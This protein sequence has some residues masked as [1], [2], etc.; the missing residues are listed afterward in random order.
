M[1][2]LFDCW[3]DFRASVPRFQ[4]SD[5][6]FA[7]SILGYHLADGVF[8]AGQERLL[9]KTTKKRFKKELTKE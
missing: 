1:E 6:L 7:L 9:Q 2:N 4:A 8:P 3:H 5:T